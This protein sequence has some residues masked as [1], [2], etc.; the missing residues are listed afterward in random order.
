MASASPIYASTC[1]TNGSSRCR[2]APPV[3]CTLAAPGW[4]AAT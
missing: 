2:P 4:L 3:S 1:W